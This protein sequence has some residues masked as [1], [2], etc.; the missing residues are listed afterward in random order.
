MEKSTSSAVPIDDD[1]SPSASGEE[2]VVMVEEK[3]CCFRP[4]HPRYKFISH[5]SIMLTI[6][7]IVG[8][9][10][11]LVKRNSSSPGNTAPP[12]PTLEFKKL[13]ASDT[14]LF[15]F[16]ASCSISDEV[17]LVGTPW[18]DHD[19]GVAGHLFDLNGTEVNK[20][21]PAD[22]DYVRE[23]AWMWPFSMHEKIVL[24]TGSA[25]LQV[26]SRDGMYERAIKCED[27]CSSFGGNVATFGDIAVTTARHNSTTSSSD[28]LHVY[29]ITDGELLKVIEADADTLFFTEISVSDKAI[30]AIALLDNELST[31]KVVVYSISNSFEK[32]S[33]I[34]GQDYLANV[35]TAGSKMIVGGGLQDSVYLYD[36]NGT[37]LQEF[38]GNTSDFYSGFGSSVDMTDE[39]IIIG[40]PGEDE[41][42]GVVYVYSTLTGELENKIKSPESE[43]LKRFGT[44]VGASN[45]H[46]VIGAEAA[47][48]EKGRN[49]TAY[50]FEV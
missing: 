2:E 31:R 46:Y 34:G 33:E 15:N 38:K 16:G 39:K 9:S 5:G 26:F 22:E 27:D 6:I 25:S 30:V 24:D 49:G 41:G 43:D 7:A 50:L 8:L 3:D 17:V 44:C 35:A 11:F 18:N 42:K 21:I 37:L 13:I 19:Y 23:I 10:V 1:K 45:N 4:I 28:K 20:L 14:D 29:N 32:I 12:F 47:S 48:F 40:A 36:L